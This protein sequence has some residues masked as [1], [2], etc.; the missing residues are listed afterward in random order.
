[1]ST[2]AIY[3]PLLPL[4]IMLNGA[5]NGNENHKALPGGSVRKK[6]HYLVDVAASQSSGGLGVDTDHLGNDR[7]FRLSLNDSASIFDSAVPKATESKTTKAIAIPSSF[8]K[9]QKS[10]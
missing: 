9:Q 7:R 1:M 3:N 4:P 6:K 10:K 5:N 2:S 8:V